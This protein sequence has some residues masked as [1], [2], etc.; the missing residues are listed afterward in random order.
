M[1]DIFNKIILYKH[2]DKLM[3]WLCPLIAISIMIFLDIKTPQSLFAYG[4]GLFMSLLIPLLFR[5]EQIYRI[6]E[7]REEIEKVKFYE[8]YLR[9]EN[10]H[11]NDRN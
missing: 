4:I 8:E 9:M 7:R 2:L 10:K 11:D 5:I 3:M 6:L 1:K